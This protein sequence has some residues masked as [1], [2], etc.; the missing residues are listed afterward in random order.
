MKS[1]LFILFSLLTSSLFGQDDQNIEL[2]QKYFEDERLIYTQYDTSLHR[3][4]PLHF[5]FRSLY[6]FEYNVGRLRACLTII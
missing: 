6:S 2:I 5:I 1:H 3:Y 4:P